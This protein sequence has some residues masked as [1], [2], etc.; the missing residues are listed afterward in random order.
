MGNGQ[1]VKMGKGRFKTTLP[2]ADCR[3]RIEIENILDLRFTIYGLKTEKRKLKIVS[4]N[5]ARLRLEN[6]FKT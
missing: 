5:G 2:I 1:F 6:V 4:G 3:L